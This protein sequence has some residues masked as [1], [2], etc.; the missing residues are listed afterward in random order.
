MT[1]NPDQ[2][3]IDSPIT[4]LVFSGDNIMTSPYY[5]SLGFKGG[6][7]RTLS[8]K[9]VFN[10]V[11]SDFVGQDKL[12]RPNDFTVPVSHPKEARL[13]DGA[14]GDHLLFIST[15]AKNKMF[16][17]QCFNENSSDADKRFLLVSLK[18]YARLYA[19][20]FLELHREKIKKD[21]SE[22]GS[23]DLSDFSIAFSCAILKTEL[24]Y[25]IDAKENF[26]RDFGCYFS[27]ATFPILMRTLLQKRY[28]DEFRMTITEEPPRPPGLKSP[29]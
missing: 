24:S 14:P 10:F 1:Q 3:K 19:S 9:P 21:V 17:F 16:R 29:R 13:K 8:G 7:P 22:L 15:D 11:A 23:S 27:R 26:W 18:D 20:N 12:P 5:R 25:L 4:S 2:K 28:G 6:I